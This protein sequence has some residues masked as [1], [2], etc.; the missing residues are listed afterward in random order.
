MITKNN[1]NY[2]I[3]YLPSGS[4]MSEGYLEHWN[5]NNGIA[6]LT[7]VDGFDVITGCD[8]VFLIHKEI[9]S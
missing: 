2:G 8:N 6:S 4:V 9:E 1:I 7:F 3:V 5:F